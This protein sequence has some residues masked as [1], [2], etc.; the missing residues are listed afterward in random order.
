MYALSTHA[1]RPDCV[2][3]EVAA[4]GGA[5]ALAGRLH[6]PCSHER[7]RAS[8]AR[9]LAALLE[10]PSIALAALKDDALV[11]EGGGGRGG[12]TGDWG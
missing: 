6:D 9:S 3:V 4:A 7:V 8:S 1:P 2:Q 5:K 12:R 10:E 11:G